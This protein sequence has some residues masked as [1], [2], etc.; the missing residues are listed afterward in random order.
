MKH[1]IRTVGLV[2]VVALFASGCGG[3]GTETSTTSSSVVSST[4]SVATSSRAIFLVVSGPTDFTL[5]QVSVADE[6]AASDLNDQVRL[7][8]AALLNFTGTA[9][10]D[11]NLEQMTDL[12]TVVPQGININNVAIED[13]VVTVDF[14]DTIR[15]VSGSSSEETLL[16][17]QLA[18]T[19]LLDSSLTALRL[20]IDGQPISELWGHLDWSMPIAADAS[21][22]DGG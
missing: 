12:G 10:D 7:A 22:L 17:Q 2:S 1:L 11:Y 9:L 14:D 4:T 5:Q 19:A 13:G 18:H 8:L 15:L 16:A 6:E 20:V 21:L 3:A